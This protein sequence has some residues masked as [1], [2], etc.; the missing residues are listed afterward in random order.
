MVSFIAGKWYQ[1]KPSL[2]LK[3]LSIRVEL[4]DDRKKLELKNVN[5]SPL[6]LENISEFAD[7]KTIYKVAL[8][9]DTLLSQANAVIDSASEEI[10]EIHLEAIDSRLIGFGQLEKNG[11]DDQRTPKFIDHPIRWLNA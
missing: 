1:F 6:P 11:A 7:S 2:K 9:I 8:Y 4:Y 3:G 5:C 10:I